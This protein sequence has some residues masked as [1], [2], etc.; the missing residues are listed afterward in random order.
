VA[1]QVESAAGSVELLEDVNVKD[2]MET[3]VGW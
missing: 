3:G 2:I 1:A